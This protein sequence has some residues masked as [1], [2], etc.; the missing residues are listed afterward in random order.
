M[1]T[2]PIRVAAK[3][4]LVEL[5]KAGLPDWEI[6][7]GWDGPTPERDHIR[8]GAPPTSGSETVPTMKAGRKFRDDRFGISLY[9]LAATPGRTHVEAEERVEVGL[10]GVDSV[11]ADNSRLG[12]LDGVLMATLGDVD[13]PDSDPATEGALGYGRAVVNVHARLT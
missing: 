10:A 12:A 9:I 11:L 4:R 3:R 5:L 13:G 6:V 2:G 8:V 7:Y 1:P